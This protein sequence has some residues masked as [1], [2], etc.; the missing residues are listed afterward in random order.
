MAGTYFS[1]ILEGK[2][3]QYAY[4]L[5]VLSGGVAF[6]IPQVGNPLAAWLSYAMLAAL[7]SFIWHQR[8]WQWAG[9]LCLP[10]FVLICF[11]IVVMGAGG[12]LH[13]GP[14]F[15]KAMLSASLGVY[16]GSKLSVL[17]ISNR[18]AH[19]RVNRKRANGQGLHS[20]LV[21]RESSSSVSSGRAVLHSYNSNGS[22]KAVE[23]VARFYGLNGA[24]LNAA[25]EGDHQKIGLL[26][27]EGADVNAGGGDGWTP[28]MTAALDGD[29][30]TVRALFGGRVDEN[31]ACNK[32]WTALMTATIEGHVEVV[33][34][35]VEHGAQVDAR[36][37]KG[38]TALRFAVAMDE[39]AIL[40][41]LLDAGADANICDD[42]GR[43]AL[44]QAA[45][46][47]LSESCQ[48]L[49]DGGAYTQVKDRYG[50]TA[51]ML[52]RKY[53]HAKIIRLLKEAGAKAVNGGDSPVNILSDGESYL[54]LLKE[55]LEEM[56]QPARGLAAQAA[57]DT[58]SR[59]LAALQTVRE[60][61]DAARNARTLSPSEIS[62]KLMLTLQEASTLSGL[63][64][65]HLLEAVEAG[66]L[67]AQRI[68]HTWRITRAELDEHIRRLS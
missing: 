56:L 59:L 64:R 5:V 36:N 24:L 19:T 57:D 66:S 63:P 34:A 38:W 68:K 17:K 39:T 12:F 52:A 30:E 10:I 42:E 55:E 60:Q 29:V 51:L 22:K 53:G 32:G 18:F 33:R 1:S 58:A 9:W 20:A 31:A 15:A 2:S 37:N 48:A 7:F 49:L 21:P 11:D 25:R 44:M 43:T 27:G 61:L 41:L 3:P 40:R 54:Y 35:L 26:V 13:N 6:I 47:N 46:E 62:H 4:A 8:A 50:Q 28:L 65:A 67:K 14:I 45:C 23:S 16:A